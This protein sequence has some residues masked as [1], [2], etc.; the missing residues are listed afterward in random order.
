M[1]FARPQAQRALRGVPSPFDSHTKVGFLDWRVELEPCPYFD[2]DI[3][4]VTIDLSQYYPGAPVV[5]LVVNCEGTFDPST[6][7]IEWRFRALDPST[8]D[9]PEEPLAGF[10]PPMTDSGWE[11]GWVEFSASP[12]PGLPSGTTISNQAWVTFDINPP[13]PAPKEGPYI[14]TL[15]AAPPISAV[16]SLDAE[17]RWPFFLVTFEGE[18]DAG[19][20]GLAS[21]DVYV[22]EDGGAPYLY[23]SAV[24]PTD[25]AVVFTGRCGH[26]YAFYTRARDHVGNLESAPGAPDSTTTAGPGFTDIDEDFWAWDEVYWLAY[27]GI[28]Q[29]YPDG[30]YGP[31]IPVTRDQMAVYIARALAGGEE[32][33]PDP[34]C[35]APPFTDVACD[36]WARKHIAYCVNEGVVQGY[37]EGDYKPTQTVTR[38]QM[39]VYVARSIATPRGEAGLADYVPPDPRNFPDVASDFW[40]WKHVEY[41]VEQGV[42]NGY[43]DG[44]Y[45]PEWVV[46]RD[47]MAVYVARAF[48]LGP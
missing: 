30:S 10:L 48:E 23:R 38:D 7:Q 35:S 11:I 14:N 24:S 19:G 34:G 31:S 4:G 25:S 32:N 45:H 46:T 28:S 37:P 18:D 44:L 5:D 26:D 17:Q 8:Y 42:V 1:I 29:G 33:V 40:A 36:H 39:A 12:L 22:S 21:Y 27:H 3:D 16:Q 6:G 43:E 47:Q 15:D 41:C 9:Y 13:N 2:L 20:C